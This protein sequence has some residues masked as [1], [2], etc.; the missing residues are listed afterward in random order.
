MSG[1]LAVRV[2]ATGAGVVVAALT[3]TGL[4]TAAVLH[5]RA[6]DALDQA[7]LAAAHAYTGRAPDWEVEHVS[8]PVEAWLA[9]PGDPRVPAALVRAAADADRPL[10]FDEG[11]S[12]VV[13]LA[14]E[15][16]EEEDDE[17]HHVVVA[18][19]GPRVTLAESTGP[20]AAAY[21]GV[22][23]L[24]AAAAAVVQLLFVRR[25]FRP[26][27]RARREAD[28]VTDLAQ[29]A[30]LTETGPRE[31]SDF[32]RSINAI[33][34]R[35]DTA[36]R[37]Q[38]RFSDEAAHELRTPV[39]VM[40]GELDVALRRERSAAEYRGVLLS[41]REEVER[42]RAL[43]E[44]LVALARVDADTAPPRELVAASALVQAAAASEAET[45]ARAGSTLT[46]E[47]VADGPVS[48]HRALVEVALAN[49]L[50]NAAVHAGGTPV[51]LTVRR[52]DPLWTFTVEDGGP[53]VS[54][55]TR[56]AVFDRLHRGGEARRRDREGLGLG[57]PLAREVARRHGGDC[58]IEAA[59]GCRVVFT[60][61]SVI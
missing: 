45:L 48:V 47:V 18:A 44:G 43:V 19:S 38:L 58:R 14:A 17:D 55:D 6:H 61:R 26:V 28:R 25:A 29:G 41:T 22:G 11:G 7:L 4:G 5:S 34:D 42:L 37:A 30:R 49:L 3:L 21:V 57:L 36:H 50:R 1:S 46:V 33:L 31:V 10:F 51:R 54:D 53:G 9:T 20:F 60:V 40:L 32:L 23:A 52:A 59:D 2:A 35:L 13:L 16:E 56:E 39:T 8:S 24:A 27:D 15:M 12:R